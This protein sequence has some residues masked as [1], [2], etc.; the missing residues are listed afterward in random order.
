MEGTDKAAAKEASIKAFDQKAKEFDANPM[1][2]DINSAASKALKAEVLQ[3]HM[4]VLDFGCGTGLLALG[5]ADSVASV[6]GVDNSSG[7]IEA[8][9]AKVD[10]KGPRFN[11]RAA[12]VDLVDPSS[13]HAA[14]DVANPYP[15][16][17]DVVASTMTFHHIENI[18][19]MLV[20]LAHHLKPGGKLAVFDFA[21]SEDSHRF[22]APSHAHTVHHHGG[23]TPEDFCK[24]FR[25]AGLEDVS[26]HEVHRFKKAAGDDKSV[27]LEFGLLLAV[28][29]RKQ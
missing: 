19:D 7:M 1:L 23:F 4:D 29:T 27:I 9:Q 10:A 25:D 6:L 2:L 28:G 18:T 22:H 26:C 15:E 14:N 3:P 12:C 21:K 8:L 16:K 24:Y 5:I 13:L 20:L 11:V 17:F